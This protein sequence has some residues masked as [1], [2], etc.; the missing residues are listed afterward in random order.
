MSYI[1]AIVPNDHQE[2]VKVW[3]RDEHGERSVKEYKAPYF[4]YITDPNG[5]YKT[6]FDTKVK[7][8][9]CGHNRSLFYK[10]RNEYRDSGIKV[11]ESDISPEIRVLSNEYYERPAPKLNVTFIDIENDYSLEKGFSGP[12]NP[13]AP[14]NAVALFHEHTQTMVAL[15]TPHK[16]DPVL[17][18]NDKLE[19]ACNHILPIPTDYTMV[20][21]VCKDEAELLTGF[22]DAIQNSDLLAGWNCIPITQ[23]IWTNNK[24]IKIKDSRCSMS[25]Y[26]SDI[27][28]VSSI[29]KKQQW[30]ITLTNGHTIQSSGEH[31][32][33]IQHCL[34]N[35]YID[36]R[37]NKAL[38]EVEITPSNMV[39]MT[40]TLFVEMVLRKNDQLDNPD[41]SNDQ[42]YL[43][44]LIYTDGT[45]CKKNTVSHGFSI[46][47]SDKN[48][49][50]SLPL[51]ETAI[52]GPHKNCYSRGVKYSLISEATALIYD[53]NLSKKLNIELLSTLSYS[54]FM[55]FLSGLLDGDGYIHSN[56]I[57]WCN[58]NNDIEP[59]FELCLWNGIFSTIQNYALRLVL[60]KYEDLTLLKQQRWT[61]FSPTFVFNRTTK[62]KAKTTKYKIIG[63][64]IY[65]RIAKIEKTSEFVDMMDIETNNHHYYTKG[66]KTHNSEKFDF[67]FIAKRIEIVLGAHKLREMSFIGAEAPKFTEVEE[68]TF[69]VP[70]PTAVK[71]TYI[72]LDLSGRL[73]AD[74]MIL[75]KKYEMSEKPS[76][77]LATVSEDVLVDDNDVAL[78]PKLEYEGTLFD[79]YLKDFAFFVRYNIRDTEILHGFEQKLAYVELA[80]QMY[81][82]SC[83][84]F[85][86]VGGT[87]KLAELAIVNHCHHTLNRVVNNVTKPLIDKQIEGALV[88]LPQTG[89]HENIGSIDINSLYPTAI[90][91]LNISPEKIRGQFKEEAR[92]CLEIS[93][94]SDVE[95]TFVYELSGEELTGTAYDWGEFLLK[96]KWA[97]SGYGTVFDQ[98]APGII[99]VILSGWFAQRKVYQKKKKEAEGLFVALSKKYGYGNKMSGEDAIL[100]EKYV[101][102]ESYYDRLQYVFKIKL[103]SLYGAMSNLYFRF[104]DLRMGESTTGTGRM[105][106]RHQCRKVNEIL[107]GEYNIDFPMYNTIQ[108]AAKMG[109]PPEVALDGPIFQGKFQTKSVIYGDTDSTYFTIDHPDIEKVIDISDKVASLVN[110]SYQE[111]MQKT[112]LCQPQFDDLVKCGR[113]VVSDRGIFVEKKR[114]ILHLIDIEGKRVDKCKVMG[115]DT[116]KTTLP[117]A[118]SKRLNKFIELYLKGMTWEEVSIVM[119]DYKTELENSK[120]ISDIGLPKGVK[121]VEEY[122]RKWLLDPKTRL[123]GHVAAAIHYN[124]MLELYEDR[125]SMPIMSG[126]KLKVFYLNRHRGRFKSIALPTDAEFVPTWFLEDFDVDKKAHILRLV[127]NPLQNIL[128]A[129]GKKTPTKE[130]LIF[131]QEWEF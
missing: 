9:D 94:L 64:K 63:D 41:F 61:N 58:F 52:V 7:K 74:Y 62:Q 123:P 55:S 110:D 112:F 88:L 32:F 103:N 70:D 40:D 128:K 69:G 124:N 79:L 92:A 101:E 71:Q 129:V 83:G 76:Y 11:W 72:R 22:L 105:I 95:L 73:L 37:N 36:F 106:L 15:A 53:N 121:N 56:T 82:L 5:K 45:M 47:Q 131:D 30:N 77:K 49:L 25:L 1:S 114:Y 21:H 60:F 12:K 4:F 39:D 3:E 84:K 126:M 100:Y 81:H 42:L 35:K 24:I 27:V 10:K 57:E 26:D 6:I 104:Y 116:K 93:K 19:K 115:L 67:P 46:F 102:E 122:T 50:E 98:D 29:T 97:I 75:F 130:S 119:V 13:Y 44:G 107:E 33:F 28:N 18:D 109:H 14:I 90:R 43:A 78:L 34:P 59:L 48:M 99:P 54:Q 86:H 113:E 127:D 51:V 8:I 117:V 125:V 96:Q 120:D 80:N 17:W 111:F 20:F 65:I 85:E 66:I 23:S 2:I 16:D 31:K 89:M 87:L 91:S 118:V 108:D 68:K 38:K